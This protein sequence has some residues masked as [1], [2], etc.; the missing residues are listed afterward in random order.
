MTFTDPNAIS[1]GL[2]AMRQA[3]AIFESAVAQQSAEQSPEEGAQECSERLEAE[4][5]AQSLLALRHALRESAKSYPEAVRSLRN[6]ASW[7]FDGLDVGG[8]IE[9]PR[10]LPPLPAEA[11]VEERSAEAAAPLAHVGISMP[12]QEVPL[13]IGG[14]SLMV[15][16]PGTTDEAQAAREAAQATRSEGWSAA[17][18]APIGAPVD[19]DM[20]LVSTR[21]ALKAEGCDWAAQYRDHWEIEPP[22]QSLRIARYDSIIARAKVLPNCYVWALNSKLTIPESRRMMQYAQ[23]YRNLG[24]AA[25]LAQSVKR[26]GPQGGRWLSDAYALLAEAQSAIRAAIELD[27]LYSDS[28]QKDCFRWLQVRTSEDRIVVRHHMRLDDPADIAAADDLASRLHELRLRLIEA[29]Q[30]DSQKRS[31]IGKARYH[32]RLLQRNQGSDA[33]P[34]WRK[35]VDSINEAVETYGVPPSD[36]ELRDILAPLADQV[37]ENWELPPAFERV[38]ESVD[39]YLATQE[40]EAAAHDAE[41]RQRPLSAEVAEVACL[42]EGQVAVLI[43]GQVRPE[44]K[45]ALE[46]DLHL[47]ELRWISA[48]H[49]QSHYLFESHVARPEV[50]LV[51]LAIRWSAHSFG[52]VDELCRRHGKL[53]VRLPGG[54]SPNQVARQILEQ[55]GDQL[56]RTHSTTVG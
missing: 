39:V 36:I 28:D 14:A 26:D 54:Y 9:R 8:P 11:H 50:T 42:M 49:H 43:G 1:K 12:E 2:Q 46:R 48:A 16:V 15:N 44:S 32:A 20:Q 3:L 7:L 45:R 22:D 17:P 30:H 18:G 21:C 29:R 4:Q 19:V 37:P 33:E 38:M 53:Y 56:R 25:E 47:A 35:L 13:M 10:D 34:D 52:N 24:A 41:P 6:L 23:A 55:V 5:L 51:M 27:G 31:V 40:T